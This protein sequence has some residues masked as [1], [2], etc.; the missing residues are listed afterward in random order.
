MTS[1]ILNHILQTTAILKLLKLPA[2]S[3]IQSLRY[4]P[5]DKGGLGDLTFELDLNFE[6]WPASAPKAPPC[7]WGQGAQSERNFLSGKSRRACPVLNVWA[8]SFTF[9]IVSSEQNFH[10]LIRTNRNT[11]FTGNAL[12]P[13][14]RNLHGFPVHIERLGWAD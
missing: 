6:L 11:E 10:R 2:C 1:R 4:S 5:L 9:G 13:I 3:P 8:G 7:R 14:E 12:V